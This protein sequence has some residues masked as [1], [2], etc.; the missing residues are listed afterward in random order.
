MTHKILIKNPLIVSMDSSLRVYRNDILIENDIISKISPNIT[1]KCDEIID[2]DEFIITP[3]FIQTHVHLCQTL[4]RNMAEDMS[5]LEWLNKKIWPFESL[6]TP[7]TLTISAELGIAELIKSGTTTIMDMGTVHHH[8]AIFEVLKRSGMRAVS[9]KAMMDADDT[10]TGLKETTKQSIDES[11]RLY[12]KWHNFDDGRLQY[13]FAPRFLLSCSEELLKETAR[14]AAETGILIHTHACENLAEVD[15]INKL[16]GM[17]NIEY[18]K[19]IGISGANLCLAH[20]VHLNKNEK[21]ILREDDIKVIHCPTANLKL[22]SGI[23][24]IPEYLKNNITV[25]IGA[26]GAPCNNN[27]NIFN[28]FRL[29]GLIQRPQYG[30]GAL[31][32]HELLKMAT[33]NGA[34]TIQQEKRIGSIEE[35]KR[36]DLTFIRENS[37]HSIPQS[38]IYNKIIYSAAA[39]DVQHVMINGKWVL[40]NRK[41]I[42][43][44]ENNILKSAKKVI[45]LFLN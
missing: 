26:D 27:L 12:K 3:G 28:E 21:E 15:K 32:A 17:G 42:T 40:K 19:K 14:I 4:F 10:L 8:E 11:M 43:L 25:S 6:H 31:P 30:V 23:A 39:S 2:A 33:I 29:A 16:Y 44:N 1:E 22:G 35:G 45:K 24:P 41:L 5:L 38:D 20:C 34:K 9:G 7:Q 37:I 13:A 18:F 36:A